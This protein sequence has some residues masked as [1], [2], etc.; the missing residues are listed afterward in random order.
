MK[1]LFIADTYPPNVNGAAT[2]AEQLA[3]QLALHGH[4]VSVIAPSPTF[5]SYVR[6][7]NA[8]TVY[9]IKSI[10]F[11]IEKAQKFRISPQPLHADKVKK[12]I[13]KVQPDIIHVFEPLWLGLSGI[14]IGR[15]KGIPVV[16]SHHFIPENLIRYQQ[17]PPQMQQVIDRTIWRWYKNVC[18]DVDRMICP[19]QKAA[20]L[21]K[22]QDRSLPL[23]VISNG[24][25]LHKFS[26]HT[27]GDYLRERYHIPQ[28]ATLLY[29]GRL[30]KEKNIDVF[31]RAL[32]LLQH[33]VAFHAIIAGQGKE[34]KFLKNLA[35]DL[36]ISAKITFTGYVPKKDL[37]II[38]NIADIFVMPS[39]AELQSLVT[40]EA[41]A[42]GLP[43]IGANALALPHLIHPNK[44]GFLFPPGNEQELAD[45][46]QKLIINEKLR[47]KMGRESL[48][49]IR[50][51]DLSR[52]ITK[53]E[54][55]YK[56]LIKTYYTGHR[57]ATDEDKHQMLAKLKELSLK[58]I[59][60]QEL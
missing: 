41:M 19:T 53:V 30:D 14:K 38:Y 52:V 4:A 55:V 11:P 39:T 58:K 46:L 44:N 54:E 16:L 26:I 8:I 18:K 35:E 42:S 36:G 13:A 29:V 45:L 34:E 51:H 37:P 33:R 22:K 49:F 56:Q 1:I 50:E 5:R 2:A 20:E 47:K 10:P 12:I 59:F 3:K 48:S 15:K 6:R 43:I 27:T 9:R 21:L 60:L 24:I 57:R 17:L 7:N 25:D 23:Q 32:G 31:I 28:V 40:M